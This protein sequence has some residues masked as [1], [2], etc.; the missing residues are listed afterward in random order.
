MGPD[1]TSPADRATARAAA[2]PVRPS[3]LAW[4]ERELDG[5]RTAGVVD[6]VQVHAIRVRYVAVRRLSL[7]KLLLSLGGAF[8]GVGLIWLV[9]ANL[10][11]LSPLLR[12]LAVTVLWLGSVLGAEL[13]TRRETAGRPRGAGASPL[14]EV[15]HLLAA[16]AFGAVV[17][18]AAQSLQVPAYEPA[19]LGWWGL[20]AL[21][22]AY[23][24]MRV[25]PLL[26]GISAATGWYVWEV[27]G[28]AEDG[29]GF[30]L[31]VLLAAAVTGA[32]G[33]V[34]V[35]RGRAGFA[36]CWR[37]V[38]ALLVLLGLF[39]A[40]FPYVDVEDFTWSAPVVAGIV[41]ALL[42]AGVATVIAAP[43]SRVE[44]VAPVVAGL[45]GV[46]LVL[47][48]P[49]EPVLG[50]VAAEG[51]A[52]AFVSVAVY[53]V[54]AGWYA[55]AGVRQDS[56]AL[57]ALATVALVLFTTV[58]SFAVFA[59]IITGASLF[60]VLGVVLL[61]SG[62]LFDRGRRRLVASVEGAPS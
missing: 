17:F 13:L 49:P 15:A 5:W 23:A 46:A 32:V 43:G 21:L 57:T 33:V 24:V 59:P 9:A 58:Q 18:Q 52:H 38:S 6:D 47:W 3:Q 26:V 7:T 44:A 8:L 40:A 1:N 28:Q 4:L 2:R 27:L 45:V 50:V 31:P 20:G 16:L 54:A 53:L 25:A 48:E 19:L 22:Y 41:V 35:G 34:H 42:A 11:Q 10:D 36:A 12:F 39:V 61:A 14:A 51:Y 60:L 55:V 30:V 29:M 62:Y 56:S 37:Q